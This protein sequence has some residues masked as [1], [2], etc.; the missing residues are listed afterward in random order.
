MFGFY[1]ASPKKKSPTSILNKYPKAQPKRILK[2]KKKKKTNTNTRL[3]QSSNANAK[4]KPKIRN[5]KE[6]NLIKD[7]ALR[8]CLKPHHQAHRRDTAI[9][10]LPE[11]RATELGSGIRD[12][13]L[14]ISPIESEL[15][16][17]TERES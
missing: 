5:P 3:P 2:L 1:R 16:T 14:E 8:L 6:K 11:T 13:R 15:A 4:A 12:R 9:V 10:P 17:P 7:N